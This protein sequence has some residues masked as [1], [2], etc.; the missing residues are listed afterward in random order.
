ME[1]YLLWVL[2]CSSDTYLDLWDSRIGLRSPQDPDK[3]CTLQDSGNPLPHTTTAPTHPPTRPRKIKTLEHEFWMSAPRAL[4]GLFSEQLPTSLLLGGAP[5]HD[6]HV[7]QG[8]GLNEGPAA[9]LKSLWLYWVGAIYSYV[10]K[11]SK[12]GGSR[13][14]LRAVRLA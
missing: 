3:N 8:A 12:M 7:E 14:G 13:Y 10:Q 9:F 1:W 11:R 4:K 2:K 6:G 5:F